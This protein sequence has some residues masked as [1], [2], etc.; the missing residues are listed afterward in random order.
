MNDDVGGKMTTCPSCGAFVPIGNHCPN[1]GA[2]LVM[3]CIRC[4]TSMLVG[5]HF[6]QKCGQDNSSDGI[7]YFLARKAE[8]RRNATRLAKRITKYC[9]LVLFVIILVFAVASVVVRKKIDEH[10]EGYFAYDCFGFYD[11][12]WVAHPFFVAYVIDRNVDGSPIL[13]LYLFD[14]STGEQ[15]TSGSLVDAIY[16]G[17]SGED[18][19]DSD[20]PIFMYLYN[21]N[22]EER[23]LRFLNQAQEPSASVRLSYRNDDFGI[24]FWKY[25][26]VELQVIQL[27]Q[28]GMR[29]VWGQD[30]PMRKF[31][32]NHFPPTINRII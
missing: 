17:I 29:I 23:V 27:N 12:R 2:A 28:Y 21:G 5:D 16:S 10:Y 26:D 25:R 14:E 19:D 20:V 32:I 7:S 15:L 22:M 13:D 9:L 18:W 3:R 31:S 1:C 6:C 11:E 4:G 24:M 8:R 30:E